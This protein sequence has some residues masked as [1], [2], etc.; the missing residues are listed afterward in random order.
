MPATSQKKKV[1]KEAKRYV[2]RIFHHKHSKNYIYKIIII[3]EF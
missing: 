2:V 1:L 3:N